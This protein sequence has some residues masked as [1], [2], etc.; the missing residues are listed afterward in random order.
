MNKQQLD[1]M[2]KKLSLQ[3][4][5]F[6]LQY[7]SNN[8]WKTARHLKILTSKLEAVERGEIKR[9]M[10]QIGP[11]HGKSE[12]TS[13]NFPAW[14]LMRNPDKEV[15][16]TSYSSEIATDFSRLAK[17]KFATFAP[18]LTNLEIAKDSAAA[19]RWGVQ[20]HN[21]GCVAVG[22]GG[23]LTGRGGDII[24]ID[25]YCKSWEEATSP[26]IK[27]KTWEWYQSVLR[28]RLA[29]NGAIIIVATPWNDDDLAARLKNK[30]QNGTGEHWEIVNIPAI[31]T[32]EDELGRKPGEVLWPERF[33]EQDYQDMKIAVG[34]KVWNALYMCNPTPDDGTVFKRE[35]FKYYNEL[36]QCE[37]FLI[38]LDATFTDSANSDYSVFTLWGKRG[39]EYYLID[40]VRDQMNFTTL[41]ATFKNFCN[42][43]PY[44]KL[45]L[46]ENAANG[47]ALINLLRREIG[48]IVPVN[49]RQSKVIRAQA[50]SPLFEAG[51]VYFPNDKLWVNDLVEEMIALPSG[52]HDDF[53]DSTTQAINYFTDNFKTKSKAK[54][55][56]Y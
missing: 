21:G 22:I 5:E 6:F 47:V 20:G 8:R 10:I 2:W 46:V 29:P 24:L 4:Y 44:A 9:L 41:L 36:P 15:I 35:W 27:E 38:S 56:I 39:A 42:K 53:V 11:R 18:K 33:S 7:T 19:A 3:N 31:A 49:P 28:T 23:A 12:V 1:L 37:Q 34:S 55:N 50:V 48:G 17:S 30:M 32:E 54:V 13:K 52:K 45:K 16:V 43:H 51:N 26:T 25:D 40:A 14:Y